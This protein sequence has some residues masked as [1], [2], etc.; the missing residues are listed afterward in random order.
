M[1]DDEIELFDKIAISAMRHYLKQY[2]I[3]N[4]DDFDQYE[5]AIISYNTAYDMIENRRQYME[6][7]FNKSKDKHEHS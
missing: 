3:D 2:E 4:S 5:I 1:T 6:I 7:M